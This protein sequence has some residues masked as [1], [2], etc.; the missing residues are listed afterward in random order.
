MKKFLLEEDDVIQARIEALLMLFENTSTD[1][2]SQMIINALDT[3]KK[4]LIC[5]TELQ[6]KVSCSTVE[7]LVK[8]LLTIHC[9]RKE[10]DH[11]NSMVS[12]TAN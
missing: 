2:S 12:E 11:L 7:V 6:N 1:E 4:N 8:A 10:Y 9:H 5:E 3:Y